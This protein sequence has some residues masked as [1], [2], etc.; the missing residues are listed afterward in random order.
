MADDACD[1][2]GVYEANSRGE[3]LLVVVLDSIPSLRVSWAVFGV[4]DWGG[5]SLP[6]AGATDMVG[7]TAAV[8][9]AFMV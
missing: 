2:G 4:V 7:E 9:A 8:V 6:P 3:Q 1:G 5:S